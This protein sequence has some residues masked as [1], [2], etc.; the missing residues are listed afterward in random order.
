MRITKFIKSASSRPATSVA[1]LFV[2]AAIVIFATNAFNIRRAIEINAM[3]FVY[4]LYSWFGLYWKLDTHYCSPM[5][6]GFTPNMPIE[7]YR[8]F[9][10]AIFDRV[11]SG[12]NSLHSDKIKQICDRNLRWLKANATPAKPKP[13]DV[14]YASDPEFK[15]K[16]LAAVKKPVPF[17]I[18]G[19]N[20]KCFSNMK[21]D[22]LMETAGNNK[23]YMSP[24]S[25]N[26]CQDHTF[27]ELKAI[28]K[29][30]CYVANSTNLFTKYPDLLP[31]SDMDLIKD[32]IDGYMKNDT[33]QLFVGIEKGSGTALH[34]AY[35][36]NFFLMIQGRK[37]WTFFNPNQLALLYPRFQEKGIYMASET[38]FLNAE[39]DRGIFERFPLIQ[40]AE[41]Y[42][43]VLEETDILYNP[44]SWFH[45]VYNVTEISVACSTRWS[46]YPTTIPDSHMLRYGTLT[47]PTL[48]TYVKDIYIRTGIIGISQIDE[49]KHMIGENNQD[50]LPFW[51]KH[52]NDSAKTCLNENCS[53]HWHNE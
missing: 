45:S 49:H 40:Y 18:K 20:L 12:N 2:F 7:F 26:K 6:F 24:N 38:R 34:M 1:Y 43:C 4:D 17:V 31:D 23:V 32:V 3:F 47:N 50:A 44:S 22:K 51:D 29:N 37:K 16:V 19:F 33:K 9:N 48:R 5:K 15:T 41:R 27:V 21:I 30:Y 42:E 13:I 46:T 35:T 52:T 10:V 28:Y 25:N 8:D 53:K 39:T 14:Y 11:P 36:N